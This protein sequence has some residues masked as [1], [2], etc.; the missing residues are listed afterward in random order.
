MNKI[1][2]QGPGRPED[3]EQRS[4]RKEKIITAALN[5]FSKCDFHACPVDDIANAAGVSKGTVFNYFEN[6]ETLF[7]AAVDRVI[8][9]LDEAM[10]SI[11]YDPERPLDY[12]S[13][14]VTCYLQFFDNNSKCVELL[15][16]E[17]AIFKNNRQSTY[18]KYT[19]QSREGWEQFSREL[20]DRGILREISVSDISQTIGAVLF[21][22]IF[23][24]YFSPSEQ[25][26]SSKVEPILDIIFNGILCQD[27]NEEYQQ[28]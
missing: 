18:F 8:G 6:K 12:L 5:E 28:R 2:K 27:I 19:E 14:V 10:K 9:M 25:R 17:R 11:E 7:L 3:P 16:Q 13:D 26:L 23:E 21:G 15:I 4:Q 1:K 22:L 24:H 20:I